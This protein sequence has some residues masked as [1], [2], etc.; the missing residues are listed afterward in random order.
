MDNKNFVLYTNPLQFFYLFLCMFIKI[1]LLFFIHFIYLF[2]LI[3]YYFYIL[4][5]DNDLKELRNLILLDF[6]FQ[7]KISYIKNIFFDLIMFLIMIFL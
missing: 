1:I 6:Y 5:E 3:I 2:Y 7:I 4:V